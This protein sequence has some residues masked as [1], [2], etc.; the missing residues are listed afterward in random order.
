MEGCL[1]AYV[2]RAWLCGEEPGQ[3]IRHSELRRFPGREE[4]RGSWFFD[5]GLQGFG[6]GGHRQR[7]LFRPVIQAIEC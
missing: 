2:L 1:L 4:G 5:G 7:F 3:D 6:K